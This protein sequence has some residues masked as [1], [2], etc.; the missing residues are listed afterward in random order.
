[1]GIS[2]ASARDISKGVYIPEIDTHLTGDPKLDMILLEN[3][4][5]PHRLYVHKNATFEFDGDGWTVRF[6]DLAFHVTAEQQIWILCEVFLREDYCFN[7][8]PPPGLVVD[9]GMNFG[10]ASVYFAKKYGCP[11]HSFE[12]F[13][14]TADHAERT[15]SLN[16]KYASQIQINRF[17][18]SDQKQSLQLPYDEKFTGEAS[19]FRTEGGP[20][21]SMVNVEVL[22]ASEVLR[23]IIEGTAGKPVYVKMDCEGSEFAILGDLERVGLLGHIAG[24]VLEWHAFA[25]D[26][27]ILESKLIRAGFTLFNHH[28]DNGQLGLI[29]AS[30]TSKGSN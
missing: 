5:S 15:L 26:P 6:E 13:P 21:K 23:P 14:A 22:P 27:A 2:R 9:I 19:V 24:L 11:V 25:G 10:A 17:G 7:S 4:T 12:L 1:L 16:P 3:L 8:D 28:E 18:L 20:G 30:R 29:M